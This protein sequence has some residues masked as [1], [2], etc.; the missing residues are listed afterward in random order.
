MILFCYSV[1][2]DCS[3]AKKNIKR[4]YTELTNLPITTILSKLYAKDVITLKEKQTIETSNFPLN[5]DKMEYLLDSVITPSLAN[6][7]TMKF[8]G[9]LEVMEE[10]GDPIL[11]NM[12][13][14]LG[15]C[16]TTLTILDKFTVLAYT[17]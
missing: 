6:D 13:K 10:S 1:K 7:V 8:K 9:F 17:V 11:L 16:L 2:F 3:A 12:A 5:S 14:K 4:S 15:M